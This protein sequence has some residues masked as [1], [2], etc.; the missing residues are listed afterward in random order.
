MATQCS[1]AYPELDI[2]LSDDCDIVTARNFLIAHVMLS[3]SFNPSCPKDMQYL[4]DLWY[5]CQWDDITRRRFVKDCK[6]LMDRQFDN[7]SI[8][9][10]GGHFY[11]ELSKILKSWLGTACNMNSKQIKAII[12]Q[13]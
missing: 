5:G 1:D 7:S 2:H 11:R 6:L 13:R 8:I 3:D 9:A 4:W 10:H 12:A